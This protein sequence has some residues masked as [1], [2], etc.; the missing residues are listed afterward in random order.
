M[1]KRWRYILIGVGVA[2]VAIEVVLNLV[3]SPQAYIEVTNKGTAPME[4]V[5]ARCDGRVLKLSDVAPGGTIGFYMGATKSTV[6][7]LD[8]TQKGSLLKGIEVDEFDP[9]N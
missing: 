5:I 3:R 1:S 8:F 7:S 9:P 2:F 6:L 4:K